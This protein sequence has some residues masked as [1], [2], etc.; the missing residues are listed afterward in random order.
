[1]GP[2]DVRLFGQEL[3]ERSKGGF[4]LIVVDVVLGFV[5]EIVQGV[6]EF[7]ASGLGRFLLRGGLEGMSGSSA[8]DG[9][10]LPRCN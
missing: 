9:H 2:G 5:E 8:Q 6:G 4:E 10:G 1:V 7:L 3:L